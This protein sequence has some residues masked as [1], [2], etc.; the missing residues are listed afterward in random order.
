MLTLLSK[1]VVSKLIHTTKGETK[2]QLTIKFSQGFLF[3]KDHIGKIKLN[4]LTN[5]KIM[6]HDLNKLKHIKIQDSE[7]KLL[8]LNS[9]SILWTIVIVLKKG[10]YCFIYFSYL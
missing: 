2:L 9:H 8:T 3:F 6:D 10:Q 5:T 4:G 7:K 1:T